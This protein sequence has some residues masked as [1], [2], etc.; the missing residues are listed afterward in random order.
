MRSPGIDTG[1]YRP[2]SFLQG[3]GDIGPATGGYFKVFRGKIKGNG[4]R[5]HVE[6]S[7]YIEFAGDKSNRW[8]YRMVFARPYFTT[9]GKKEGVR[10][11]GSGN[12]GG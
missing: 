5:W 10:E 3:V 4:Q 12:V 6:F 2:G 1:L 9:T 7:H 8:S 11:V